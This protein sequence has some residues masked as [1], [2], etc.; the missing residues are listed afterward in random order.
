MPDSHTVTRLLNSAAR[1]D[2]TAR[3]ELYGLVYGELL[4][5]ARS[6]LRREPKLK[7]KAPKSLV[8][9]VFLKFARN[10]PPVWLDR[11]QFYGYARRAMWQICVDEI[12]ENKR[13]PPSQPLS[14]WMAEIRQDPLEIVALD[15]AL[16]K[17]KDV[18]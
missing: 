3:E 7:G 15:T 8:H 17:L 6:R 1:G 2:A 14:D 16:K 12:R 4:I 10:G 11:K 13:R 9:E 18:D 5:L